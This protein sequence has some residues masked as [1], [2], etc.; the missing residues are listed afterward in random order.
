MYTK[1]LTIASM[2][3]PKNCENFIFHFQKLNIATIFKFWQRSVLVE[4]AR[5]FKGKNL[6]LMK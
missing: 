3:I 1:I 2:L 6:C 5:A 4:S